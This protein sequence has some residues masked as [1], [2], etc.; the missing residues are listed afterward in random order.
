MLTFKTN[1]LRAAL[2]HSAVKD[3]RHYLNSVCLQVIGAVPTCYLVSTD[4]FTLFAGIANVTWTN[5]PQK[6]NWSMLIPESTIKAAL[7]TAGTK[8]KTILLQSLPDGRYSL[9]NIVFTPIDGQFPN[10]ERVIP[11]SHNAELAQFNPFL[12]IKCNDS[13]NY[14]LDTKGKVYPLQYNGDSTASYQVTGAVCAVMPMRDV[15]NPDPLIPMP[16][17][18]QQSA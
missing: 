14:W 4:G 1:E 10:W 5:E 3:I 18:F 12:L 13:L 6:G 8:A 11:T 15:Y 2:C 17:S 7:K 16:S 9:G